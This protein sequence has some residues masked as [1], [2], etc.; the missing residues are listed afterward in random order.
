VAADADVVATVTSAPPTTTAAAAAANPDRH[1][2]RHLAV[3]ADPT[4]I[5]SLLSIIWDRRHEA[6]RIGMNADGIHARTTARVST[7]TS[8]SVNRAL[9]D[10]PGRNI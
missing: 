10:D 8:V 9:G 3:R 2:R 5:A 1:P 4:G 6:R 7:S